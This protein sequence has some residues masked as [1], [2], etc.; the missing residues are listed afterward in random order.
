MKNSSETS[1]TAARVA[2]QRVRQDILRGALQP[3]ARLRIQEIGARYGCGPIPT[4]EALSRLVSE[5]LVVHSEQRGFAVAPVSEQDLQELTLARGWTYEL[6]LRESIR[7]ADA[8]WE[9]RVLIA[10]HRLAKIPR[11]LSQTPPEPNPR[12]DEPHREFH[13]ALIG[14]CG[15]SWMIDVCAQL[16]DHAERYRNLSR[17]IAVQPREDEH[18][19]LMEAAL[20]RN[21][22]GA[23]DLIKRHVQL[24]A[25]TVLAYVQAKASP[26]AEGEERRLE[27][28]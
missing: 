22:D 2:Y 24:T 15:S 9:E 18:R 14:A 13:L 25:D 26:A 16:F 19:L 3:D 8:A 12:Y 10:H 27:G 28:V 4:R 21:A 7:R 17:R 6:A 1:P 11:Y 20:G 23:V 5:R